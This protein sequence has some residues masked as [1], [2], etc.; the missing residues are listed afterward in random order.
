LETKTL[1]LPGSGK[2]RLKVVKFSNTQAT[3]AEVRLRADFDG[4]LRNP[5]LAIAKSFEQQQSTNF[6]VR[7]FRQL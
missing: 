5:V 7:R 2:E 6:R 1:P 3:S 4:G